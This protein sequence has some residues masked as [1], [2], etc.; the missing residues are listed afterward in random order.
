[1]AELFSEVRLPQSVE[2]MLQKICIEQCKPPADTSARKQLELLGEEV[3]LEILRKICTQKIRY[4]LSGFIRCLAKDYATAPTQQ[5]IYHSPHKRSSD[6]CYSP[7]NSPNRE[8][9]S[10]SGHTNLSLILC[11]VGGFEEELGKANMESIMTETRMMQPA[12]E[13]EVELEHRALESSTAL[14][15]IQVL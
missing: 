11:L 4:S 10:G 6:D 7:V 15:T 5:G 12:M 1:M 13:R 3:S 8:L 14:A 2:S 9:I